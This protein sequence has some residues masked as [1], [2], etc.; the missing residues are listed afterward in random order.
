MTDSTEQAEALA[1][2]EVRELVAGGAEL[3]DVLRPHEYEAGHIPESRH[4]VLSEVAE[5]AGELDK[6]R[7]VIL[8][9]RS[10]NRSGMAAEALRNGG[11]DAHSLEGGIL[12]WKKEGE[13]I[14]PAGGYI[15][16]SGEA[17]AILEA[18]GR[19]PVHKVEPPDATE[20]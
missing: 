2:A 7:T 15:A 4:I 14:E 1:P 8:Y 12:A 20:N 5:L 17:A 16:E 18:E 3:I 9:C 10:G 11:V 6:G 13:A 19:F